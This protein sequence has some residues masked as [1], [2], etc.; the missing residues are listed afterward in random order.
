MR[1]TIP[2]QVTRY[3]NTN[4]LSGE[5]FKHVFSVGVEFAQAGDATQCLLRILSVRNINGHSFF[6]S[7]RKWA[8][9]GY[10]DLDL[11]DYPSN[12][13][14][15]EVQEGQIKSGLVELGLLV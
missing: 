15:H 6:V 8:S 3:V 12:A 2:D 11:E 1:S 10:M 13:L 9:S 5:A 4:I 14:I 7:G